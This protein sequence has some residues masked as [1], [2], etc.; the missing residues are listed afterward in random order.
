[1]DENTRLYLEQLAKEAFKEFDKDNSGTID[2]KV[3]TYTSNLYWHI[4]NEA[5]FTGIDCRVT[6]YGSESHG[7][8]GQRYAQ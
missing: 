3:D 5:L 1:M 8:R 4:G 7:Q 6:L 2:Q